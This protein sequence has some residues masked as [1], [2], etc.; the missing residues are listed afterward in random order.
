MTQHIL[1]SQVARKSNLV[2]KTI[3]YAIQPMRVARSIIASKKDY[4]AQPPIL[5]NSIPKS[6]THLVRAL[7]DTRYYGSFL[8]WASSLTLKKRP[9]KTINDY[10]QR[11]APGEVLGAH[12]HFTPE[13]AQALDS[14]NAIHLFIIRDPVEILASEAHYLARM[15][16]YHRMAREFS[17]L[18]SNEQLQLAL[19]GSQSHPEIYPPL[20]ARLKPYLGWLNNDNV[21][22]VRY[23]EFSSSTQTRHTIEKIVDERAQYDQIGKWKDREAIVA[24]ACGA[25]D[26]MSSHTK[27][28]RKPLYQRQE[29]LNSRLQWIRT[30]LGY[31]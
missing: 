8:A 3:A 23:E 24:Q 11:I 7:P 6:G 5:V 26:P 15:N 25:L 9:Q 19:N 28:S 16:P 21:L 4:E 13:T 10:I 14:I 12:L 1:D 17:N 22:T 20:E 27:S 2:R 29:E 18:T 31:D 30:E